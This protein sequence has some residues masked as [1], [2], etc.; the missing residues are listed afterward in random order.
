MYSTQETNAAE[1]LTNNAK[2]Q[3]G[4]SKGPMW[5]LLHLNKLLTR[6]VAYCNESVVFQADSINGTIGISAAQD[7]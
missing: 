4:R 3:M 5:I 2:Q 1:L 7:H 6:D